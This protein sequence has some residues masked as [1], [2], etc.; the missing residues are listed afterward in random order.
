MKLV[1][2]FDKSLGFS[3]GLAWVKRDGKYGAI[4]TKGETIVPFQYRDAQEHHDGLAWADRFNK[5]GLELINT[6][7]EIVATYS[8]I[9]EVQCFS[10]GL[11]AVKID[12]KWGYINTAGEVVI[13]PKYDEVRTF[14]DGLALVE[15]KG[16]WG[17]INSAG[18][19]I[20]PCEY[21][22]F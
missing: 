2:I 18:E 22:K 10:E 14:E 6:K 8:R 19:L 4:N 20:V 9:H 13:S 21:E 15:N 3:E 17:V 1:C 7:G 11:A 5:R 12:K 16:Y